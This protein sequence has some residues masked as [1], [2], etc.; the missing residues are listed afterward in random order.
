MTRTLVFTRTKHGADKVVKGLAAVRIEAAAIHGNKSQSQR[1]RALGGFKA[2]KIRVLI[3]TDIAARGIDVD[4]VSHVVN[5]DLPHVP[6]SYVHRIGRTA[7][8]GAAGKAIA[9]CDHEE[10]SLLR[11]IERTIRQK[12]PVGEHE[13]AL[14]H[15]PA[16]PTGGRPPQSRHFGG[17]K[18]GGHAG[19]PRR[20]GQRP[21]GGGGQRGKGGKPSWMRE[22]GARAGASN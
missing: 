9:F 21:N 11:D 10:R 18:P 7:R 16:E 4:G 13:L 17:G 20:N 8:A 6:E 15:V 5:Y 1:E 14:K 2:G 22:V 3:A 19:K 12:V